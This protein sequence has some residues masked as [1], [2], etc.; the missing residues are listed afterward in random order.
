MQEESKRIIEL[1]KS[2]DATNIDLAYQLI[3]G[4]TGT[5]AFKNAENIFFTK[6]ITPDVLC[7]YLE[8]LYMRGSLTI[9]LKLLKRLAAFDKNFKYSKNIYGFDDI[10]YASSWLQKAKQNEVRFLYAPKC[11]T[12]YLTTSRGNQTVIQVPNYEGISITIT[13]ENII[14]K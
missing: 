8:V 3:Y 4:K 5:K 6:N 14:V 1:L 13:N 11:E 9:V 12:E 2:Y 7:D 10:H